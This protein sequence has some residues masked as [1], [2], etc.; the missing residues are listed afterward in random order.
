MSRL[1]QLDCSDKMPVLI[2]YCLVRDGDM[3]GFKLI[4]CSREGRGGGIA[5]IMIR[6]ALNIR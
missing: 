6:K 1:F 4:L 3:S 5:L 2:G